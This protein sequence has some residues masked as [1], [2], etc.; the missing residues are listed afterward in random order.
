MIRLDQTQRH[1][2]ASGLRFAAKRCGQKRAETLKCLATIFELA[3]SATV[4]PEE[5]CSC[6][7]MAGSRLLAFKDKNCPIHG[8][9]G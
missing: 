4:T 8:E 5:N 7:P 6:E 1:D 2:I 3:S 9:K